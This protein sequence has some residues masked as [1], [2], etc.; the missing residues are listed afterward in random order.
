M[1][2]KQPNL[3]TL[4]TFLSTVDSRL[5]SMIVFAVFALSLAGFLINLKLIRRVSL[6]GK[7]ILAIPINLLVMVLIFFFILWFIGGIIVDQYPCW[8]GVPNCD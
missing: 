5:G 6:G 7:G 4:T 3:G 1:T 8:I 2:G